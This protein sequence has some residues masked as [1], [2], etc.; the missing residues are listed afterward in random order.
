MTAAG[1]AG[2]VIL[3]GV[4]ALAVRHAVYW[5]HARGLERS[6][7]ASVVKVL[8]IPEAEI[9]IRVSCSLLA[10]YRMTISLPRVPEN[11]RAEVVRL[12]TMIDA[13]ARRLAG[14]TRPT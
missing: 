9:E 10:P 6:L 11:R 3:A 2:F 4:A 14:I 8:A 7:T 13:G 5:R 1:V 12:L